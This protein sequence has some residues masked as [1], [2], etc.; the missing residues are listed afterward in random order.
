[1]QTALAH[2]RLWQNRIKRWMA[3]CRAHGIARSAQGF[4]ATIDP[5]IWILRTYAVNM[6]DAAIA[7]Y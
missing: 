2:A 1:V 3:A 7:Q 6:E 5:T 4:A